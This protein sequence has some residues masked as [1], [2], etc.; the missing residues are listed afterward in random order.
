MEQDLFPPYLQWLKYHL[1]FSN[2]KGELTHF[3]S[4]QF[5]LVSSKHSSREGE[6]DPLHSKMLLAQGRKDLRSICGPSVQVLTSSLTQAGRDEVGHVLL[7]WC[8]DSSVPSNLDTEALGA[9]R[10]SEGVL[11]QIRETPLSV[12][13]SCKVLF[14]PLGFAVLGI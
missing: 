3:N 6:H 1:F 14:S 8:W 13:R 11:L 5:L 12:N 10:G 2:I 7:Q 9:N 4:L